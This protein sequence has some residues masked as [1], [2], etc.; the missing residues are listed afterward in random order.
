METRGIALDDGGLNF[1]SAIKLQSMC[2]RFIVRSRVVKTINDEYERIFDPKRKQ[3]YYYN[4][5]TDKSTWIKPALLLNNDLA[6]AP[7]Y[8]DNQAAAKIQRMVRFHMAQL[9]VRILYQD[10]LSRS[11]DESSGYPYYF[12]PLTGVTMWDLPSF[13]NGRLDYNRKAIRKV[14]KSTQDGNEDGSRSGEDDDSGN[15]SEESEGLSEDSETL[16]AKRRAKRKYPR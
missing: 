4:K 12:N 14:K 8:T 2:R 7:T 15:D 11:I 10:V 16:R 13:M 3:F 1:F 9:K 5:R 6:V